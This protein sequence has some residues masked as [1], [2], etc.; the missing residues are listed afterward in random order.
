[1][2]REINKVKKSALTVT[3]RQE[4]AAVT[5]PTENDFKISGI[6]VFIVRNRIINT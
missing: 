5:R 1:M 2:K 4:R 3:F 6:S